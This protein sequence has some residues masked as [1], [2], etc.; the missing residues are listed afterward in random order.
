[1]SAADKKD[2]HDHSPWQEREQVSRAWGILLFGLIA[3]TAT[4]F[5]VSQLRRTADWIYTQSSKLQSSSSWRN[6]TSGSNRGGFREEAWK[7][8][9]RRMQ[10]EYEEEMQRV[11]RIRRMQSIF[12]REK[13]KYKRSYESWRD[14]G[15]GAYQ[16]IPRDDW[17][18]QTDTSYRDQRTNYRSA[19]QA[20]GSYSMSHHYSVL[21]LDRSRV[22]PY[23]DA[24]I[25]T[26][27]RAKAME[28]HPDQ[29]QDNKEAAEEKFK[30]VM[31]SYEA[32]KQERKNGI[33]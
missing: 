10:E 30:E 11:E 12:N 27:F 3:A 21:G 2:E 4:T 1:M 19:P 25:K 33:C 16:H 23:S 29:N 7:R 14:H 5:A 20:S 32:I 13:N 31:R 8:Y 9:N 22:K 28:Y 15:P 18:W 17:Y 24:E 26:A 6:A